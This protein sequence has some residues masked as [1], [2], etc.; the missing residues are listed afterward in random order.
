MQQDLKKFVRQEIRAALDP[1]GK[2]T[3]PTKTSHASQGPTKSVAKAPMSVK[4]AS[5]R[6][7]TKKVFKSGTRKSSRLKNM[8]SIAEIT[9][10]SDGNS[11]SEED[12]QDEANNEGGFTANDGGDFSNRDEYMVDTGVANISVGGPTPSHQDEGARDGGE[13]VLVG[14]Q[15]GTEEKASADTDMSCAN[16]HIL[17]SI[18][19][20][21]PIDGGEPVVV[22][23]QLG[24][25]EKPTADT[26]MVENPSGLPATSR[27]G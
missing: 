21:R 20:K 10:L 4:K 3:E 15:S 25:D 8:T 23:T 12:D 14:T 18:S 5:K 27:Q 9:Q 17:F 24:T 26:E 16:S 2:K 11:S 19:D 13:S 1:K 7:S 22:G 6:M